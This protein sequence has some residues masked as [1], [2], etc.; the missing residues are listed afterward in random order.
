MW[1]G[2]VVMMLFIIIGVHADDYTIT[3]TRVQLSYWCQQYAPLPFSLSRLAD[4]SS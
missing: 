2:L 4:A 1:I 3:V